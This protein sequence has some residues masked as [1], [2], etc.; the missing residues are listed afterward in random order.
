MNG[1]DN[2]KAALA[3]YVA[4]RDDN[5]KAALAEYVALRGELLLRIRTRDQTLLFPVIVLGT[6]LSV[7]LRDVNSH[8][9]ILFVYPL[10]AVFLAYHW[11]QSDLRAGQIGTYIRTKL[12]PGTALGWETYVHEGMSRRYHGKKAYIRPTEFVALGIFLA[13]EIVSL[14]LALLTTQL[15]LETGGLL[16]F[17]MISIVFTSVVLARRRRYHQ[18]RDE[19]RMAD[20][21]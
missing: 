17:G 19:L 12:E 7:G 21:A 10:V 3:E 5:V 11:S 8:G 16:V 15:T 6:I 14:L 18:R 4:L 2:V 13:G 1:N 9:I 20:T